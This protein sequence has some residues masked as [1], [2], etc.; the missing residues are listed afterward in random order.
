MTRHIPLLAAAT[1]LTTHLTAQ[2][3]EGGPDG[4]GYYWE[5]SSDPSDTV[6][7]SWVE[8]SGHATVTGWTPNDDDGWTRIELP[9]GFPFYGEAV[10]YLNACTNGFLQFPSTFCG[11]VNR[12]LPTQSTPFLVATFWD[13]LS[14]AQSGSIR[15]HHDTNERV[16]IIT[17]HDVV[18]HGTAE[19]LDCQSMLFADG[20]L[21]LN[22][23]RIPECATSNT[24][25]I[26]G[27]SG[28]GGRSLQYV[29]DGFPVQRIPC[30]SLS[31]VFHLRRLEH[32]VGACRITSPPEWVPGHAQVP[33][34][35]KFQNYGLNL[36]SFGV[37]AAI[38]HSRY[39]RDTVWQRAGHLSGVGP[40]D[41]ALCY[42]GDF[43]TPPSTDS[44]D[45]VL[46]STLA[47]DQYPRNDT[48]RL[49]FSS[50]PPVFGSRLQEWE[51]PDLGSGMNLCGITYRTDSGRFYF[52]TREPTAIYSFPAGPNVD[53][54]LEPFE[55]QR[56]FPDDIAWGICWDETRGRYWISHVSAHGNGC[57]LAGYHYDGSFSGDTWDLRAV[58][59][60]AWLAGLDCDPTGTL[61]AT[62][63]G[64]GNGICRLDPDR[65]RVVEVVPGQTASWR[66]CAWLGDTQAFLVTGG[67]NDQELLL[68]NRGGVVRLAAGLPDLA[69][70]GIRRPPL[71]S[72]DSLVWG[73]ATCCDGTNTIARISMGST[74]SAIGVTE[75]ALV[76]RKEAF[77][78]A[79]IVAG[80][81]PCLEGSGA[82][83]ITL[84]DASGSLVAAY[85][86]PRHGTARPRPDSR[87]DLS[88]GVYLMRDCQSNS[89]RK[90]VILGR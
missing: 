22:Y 54:R 27:N 9:F 78:T 10:T 67:W 86:L 8:P 21:R 70:F 37:R 31:I 63:V 17:W 2:T 69:D 4:Y 32:D 6:R 30:D 20:R 60:N 64:A 34:I 82:T 33:I 84:Y 77:G 81:L 44:W 13:D 72:P 68:L 83:V 45:L 23:R 19:T 29:H 5:S 90:I 12:P 1:L 46:I 79:T 24:I 36:E 14:P 28:E 71:P 53:L 11:Y 89:T 39:P 51:F 76:E 40:G 65:R 48:A 15:C 66:A 85:N 52:C 88:A 18:R 41:T 26:Q 50:F 16:T 62:R 38:I 59:P 7:F 87:L 55:L 61:W 73:C 74:W 56:F 47:G 25:G 57:V 42:L 3:D 43:A 75:P 80:P 58:E 49:V 35:G